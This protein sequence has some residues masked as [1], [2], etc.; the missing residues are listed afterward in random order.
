[1][2]KPNV[3]IRAAIVAVAVSFA[4]TTGVDAAHSDIGR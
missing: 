1:M 3:L 2:L 4:T